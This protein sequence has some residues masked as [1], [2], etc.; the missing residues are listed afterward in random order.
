M[1]AT[2]TKFYPEE[3][4]TLIQYLDWFLEHGTAIPQMPTEDGIVFIGNG[5]GVVLHRQGQ[6]Q[7]Q[8]FFT[9]PNTELPEHIHPNVDSYELHV[10]GDVDFIV[11]DDE[12]AIPFNHLKDERDGISRFWAQGIHVPAG[13]R[14]HVK[15]GPEGGLFISVQH[16]LNDI[17]P[18]SVDFDWEGPV[19]D[20][21]HLRGITTQMARQGIEGIDPYVPG[22][23]CD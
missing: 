9:E 5:P 8:L 13:C 16:W 17:K 21:R 19:M 12:H 18:T 14:H 1:W 7:S 4:T 23:L 22:Q 15:V 11:N 20:E 6:F 2:R 3:D 10:G